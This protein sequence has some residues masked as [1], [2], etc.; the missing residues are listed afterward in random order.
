MQV[1]TFEVQ[2]EIDANGETAPDIA[3]IEL[4]EKLGLTG[5]QGLCTTSNAGEESVCPYRKMTL[6]EAAV[7][8]A[9]CP[10]RTDLKSYSDEPIPL[11]V[12]QVAAHATDYFKRLEV[13][14]PTSADVKDPVLVGYAGLYSNEIFILARWGKVLDAFD[15]LKKEATKVYRDKCISEFKRLKSEIDS[16][17]LR[18]QSDESFL[19]TATPQYFFNV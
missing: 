2:K 13:W 9:L 5:Q 3:C 15:V 6:E 12:L 1:E 17:M 4:I 10:R 8:G 18:V 16:D 14:H 11:R 19:A 7:Y